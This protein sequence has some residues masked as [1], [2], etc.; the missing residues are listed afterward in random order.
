MVVVVVVVVVEVLVVFE[1]VAVALLL[2]LLP[3]LLLQLRLPDLS[4]GPADLHVVED[5]RVGLLAGLG[6]A[7]VVVE[8]FVV[9]EDVVEMTVGLLF[10]VKVLSLVPPGP[11][12]PL[13]IGEAGCIDSRC[14]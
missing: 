1:E 9:V 2:L 13:A 11:L 12:L 8:V 14:E 5:E 7:L 3:V 10:V 6:Q 4:N